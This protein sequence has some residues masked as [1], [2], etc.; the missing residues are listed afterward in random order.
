[1]KEHNEI[2]NNCHHKKKREN[3]VFFCSIQQRF[4]KEV[5][6]QHEYKGALHNK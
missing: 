6:M 5:M 3:L 2:L 4:L 1:M